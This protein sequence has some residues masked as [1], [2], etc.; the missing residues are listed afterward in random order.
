MPSRRTRALFFATAVLC[1]ASLFA[2]PKTQVISIAPPLLPTDFAGWHLDSKLQ[3]STTPQSADATNVDVLAEDGFEDFVAADYSR[4]DNKLNVRAIRFKDA[5]GAYAAYT[6]YRRPGM[7]KEDIGQGGAFDGKRV[8]FWTGATVIDATFDHITGMS[9][10]E[11]RE[12][13][14][15]VPQPP[16]PESVPPALPGY[17]PLQSLQAL[18]TRYALGP[19]GYSRSGGVLPPGILEF[20][21]DAEVLTALYSSREAEGTLTL[22]LYPTPQIAIDR[23][24]VIAALFKAGNTPQAQ[25]PQPLLASSQPSL[26]TRRSGPLVAITSGQFTPDQARKLLSQINYVADVTW[27]HPQGY[28]S[29]PTKAARLLVGV[30]YLTFILGGSAIF[31]GLFFGGGRALYRVMRGKPVST[32]SDEEFISLN[33]RE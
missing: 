4:S 13:S 28:I 16:G 1:T 6:F 17:L 33:L 27:N 26:Q 31:M 9:A 20:D 5:T 15:L 32:L 10:S 24:R 29:E 12:L 7:Q 3:P 22:L 21:H 30:I 18:T 14:G 25:W 2:A 8:L 11:L 19:Q 23:E